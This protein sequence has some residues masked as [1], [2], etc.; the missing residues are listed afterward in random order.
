M[1][2]QFDG[3]VT[4]SEAQFYLGGQ[5]NA[6]LYVRYQMQKEMAGMRSGMKQSCG[7]YTAGIRWESITTRMNWELCQWMSAQRFWRLFFW[8]QMEI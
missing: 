1:V 8:T 3:S 2:L 6:G 5:E 4:I 7:L